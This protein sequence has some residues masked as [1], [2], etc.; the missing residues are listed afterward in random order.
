M[1]DNQETAPDWRAEIRAIGKTNFEIKE[2]VRLGF[3]DLD[4]NAKTIEEHQKVLAE[5]AVSHQKLREIDREIAELGD[6]EHHLKLI[7]QRRIERV[8]AEREARKAEKAVLAIRRQA[9][10]AERRRTSPTYLGRGVSDKLHFSGSDSDALSR[11]GLPVLESFVDVATALEIEPERLQWL[12]YHRESTRTDHY[13]RFQI[14]KRSGGTRLITSPKPAMRQAQAWINESILAQLEPSQAATAFRPGLSIVDN[15][16][17]HLGAQI[18]VKVDLKDFFPSIT[19]PRVRS[20]FTS[21]GYNSGVST[22]LALLTTDAPRVKILLDSTPRYVAVGP[23][24]VPQGAITS[25]SLANQIAL[26][27]D[28]RCQALADK[29]KWTYSRYAD[30]LVFSTSHP[31]A[32][33]H[34]LL[35]TINT[36]VTDLGF[37]LNPEKT[38]IMRSPRRQ[39]V[40]GLLLGQELTLTR[41]DMRRWRAFFHRCETDGREAVSQRIGK[42]ALLVAQ[43]FHSYLHMVNPSRAEQ[44]I[45]NYPWIRAR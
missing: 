29:A 4:A 3:I 22:V 25:P 9:E 5:L 27:L 13:T 7:R 37:Q 19:F 17:R 31:Q 40:N 6:I 21:L 26:G 11:A 12:C 30:D 34:L 2:M 33:P 43:G 18:I 38:R 14:P 28:R 35:K 8:K 10:N 32:T 23:R 15:A 39:V 1:T 36:I 45:V 24:S 16:Q 41:A 20:F 44:L 42:N